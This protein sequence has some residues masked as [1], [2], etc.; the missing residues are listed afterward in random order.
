VWVLPAAA[1]S[2]ATAATKACAAKRRLQSSV[3]AAATAPAKAVAASTTA[4][5]TAAVCMPLLAGLLDAKEGAQSVNGGGLDE[6]SLHK[7]ATAAAGS[8][9]CKET[10]GAAE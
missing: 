1:T 2:K 10:T 4:A 8:A 7:A 9:G 6:E 5:T 3:A